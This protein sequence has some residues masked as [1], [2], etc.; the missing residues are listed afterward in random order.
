MVIHDRSYSR[1]QGERDRPV[2]GIWVILDRGVTTGLAQ[3][4]KRKFF[5]QLL[6]FAAFGPML[7]ALGALY[8]AFYLQANTQL[9]GDAG[10]ELAESGL[11]ELVTPTPDTVWGFFTQVQI[12]V[13]LVLCVL[14][15][16]GL[17]AEDRRT[18]ALE[19][20]LSRPL[21][22]MQYVLGK[23][24]IMAFFLAL[25]T[26]LP[27]GILLLVQSFLSGMA[28]AAVIGLADLGW[29]ALLAG[30]LQVGMLSL[31][32]VAASALCSRARNASIVWIAFLMV[33]EVLLPGMLHE[34]FL[35][36]SL[37]LVSP[38]W[39]LGRCMA[40][41]LD[42]E[43]EL[44]RHPDVPVAWS[45]LVLACWGLLC[46]VLTLRKVRPVEVVA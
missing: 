26:V 40:F 32:V 5:G 39:N 24:A 34:E 30:G 36:S 7:F 4:F 12:W 25:V 1:W 15:G 18:N 41:I 22:V 42:N 31:L 21:N 27:V 14:V 16:T 11:L 6:S 43:I 35:S 20:Y 2:R 17:V 29:R 38:Y 13:C 8:V 28:S 3:I 37:N 44:Q 9:Y 46:L 19:L 10:R 45:A 23:L 33:F